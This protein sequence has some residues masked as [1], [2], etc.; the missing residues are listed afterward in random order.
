MT[1]PMTTPITTTTTKTILPPR[2]IDLK[3]NQQN[4]QPFEIREVIACSIEVPIDSKTIQNRSEIN[5]NT[6]S[7]ALHNRSTTIPKTSNEPKISQKPTSKPIKSGTIV[8]N[9]TVFEETMVSFKTITNTV[10]RFT[11][12][13]TTVKR[14]FTVTVQRFMPMIKNSETTT[15]M[16]NNIDGL[17]N[18]DSQRDDQRIWST[19]P[20][21]NE[22][23]TQIISVKNLQITANVYYDEIEEP[24]SNFSYSN[25]DNS[26]STTTEPIIFES[27]STSSSTDETISVNSLSS[28]MTGS[29]IPSTITKSASK[30]T[31]D[32]EL[33][34]DD[35]EIESISITS[36]NEEY[37]TDTTEHNWET[38]EVPMTKSKR[39]K[40]MLKMIL[41][42]TH[43]FQ[44]VCS[45]D[46][47]NHVSETSSIPGVTEQSSFQEI[48]EKFSSQIVTEKLNPEEVTETSSEYYTLNRIQYLIKLKYNV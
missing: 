1:L 30:T 33:M 26:T 27:T 28:F 12:V 44:I 35:N 2:I 48:T 23:T 29:S 47:L 9:G 43:C 38:N 20:Q 41:N 46:Q 21:T 31:I 17:K 39:I 25:Y 14:P 15:A 32:T 6:V 11:T 36:K 22:N 24:N 5:L 16:L 18:L 45:S 37:N 4:C 10:D 19:E 8:E 3:D 13:Q 7:K 40:R 34:L 42:D